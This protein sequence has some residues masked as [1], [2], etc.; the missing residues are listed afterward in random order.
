VR[1]DELFDDLAGQLSA[2]FTGELRAEADERARAELAH[3]ALLD[4]LS[5]SGEVFVDIELVDGE[6]VHGRVV[7][8]GDGWCRVETGREEMLVPMSALARVQVGS[9]LA[10]VAPH[11]TLRRRLGLRPVLRALARRRVYVRIAVAGG[12]TVGGTV[13]A[14]GADHVELAEHPVDRPRRTDDVRAVSL[15]PFDAL[16]WLR[17]AGS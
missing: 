2:T 7:G 9:G 14:V 10:R 11:P 4:R 12:S 15:V 13:D 8:T 16:L 5:G 17:Y 6:R 1:W 3:V